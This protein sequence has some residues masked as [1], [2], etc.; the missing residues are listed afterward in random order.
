MNGGGA[1]GAGK[2]GTAF[3]P[4]QFFQR[5]PVILRLVCWLFSVI[6]FGCISSKGY[7]GDECAYNR[8]GACGFGVTLGVIAFLGSIAFLILDALFDNFSSIKTR[9]HVVLGD[10]GF[11]GG[12]A[13]F[14]FIAFC[15]LADQWGAAKWD[16]DTLD[17][18]SGNMRAAI[19]F[20]FFSIFSWGGSC[21]FAY[22]RYKQGADSAFAPSYEADPHMMPGGAPYSSYSGGHDNEEGYQEPPFGSDKGPGANFQTPAY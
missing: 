15:Y 13:F 11:C 10:L 5:P 9:K 17:D 14:W 7:V 1:Y 8:S 19:I 4:V 16:P 18:I 3:D 2:A 20:S 21:Y 22:M 6:V 12:I